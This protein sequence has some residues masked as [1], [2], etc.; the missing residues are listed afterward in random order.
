MEKVYWVS[1]VAELDNV[2]KEIRRYGGHVTMISTCPEKTEDFLAH[3]FVVVAYPQ[4]TPP[5]EG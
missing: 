5:P 1:G 3:V 2:N 4:D